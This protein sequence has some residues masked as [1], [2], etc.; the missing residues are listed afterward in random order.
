LFAQLKPSGVLVAPEGNGPVQKLCR[1]AGD[2][3]GDFVM[4]ILC[5]VR[6]VPL[7]EGVAREL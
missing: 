2:G 6:F 7:L 3:Q 4:N 5:E 1:F